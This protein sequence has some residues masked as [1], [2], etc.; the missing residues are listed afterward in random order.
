L[1]LQMTP[2][3]QQQLPLL[4][5]VQLMCWELGAAHSCLPVLHECLQNEGEDEGNH[6]AVVKQTAKSVAAAKDTQPSMLRNLCKVRLVHPGHCQQ[7][8]VCCLVEAGMYLRAQMC[9]MSV[10]DA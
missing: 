1:L 3:Q 7:E 8:A 2:E 6:R 9:C 4:L 5:L 10:F